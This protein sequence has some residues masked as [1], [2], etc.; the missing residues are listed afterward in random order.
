M[1]RRNDEAKR[2]AH[3][4]IQRRI[5]AENEAMHKEDYNRR[6]KATII[7]QRHFRARRKARL[8]G[9]KFVYDDNH[10]LVQQAR[11]RRMGQ[12]PQMLDWNL[13]SIPMCKDCTKVKA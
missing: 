8:L 2:L 12:T 9:T 7:I 13:H 10:P 5:D 1:Q 4:N 3:L 11:R 6:L